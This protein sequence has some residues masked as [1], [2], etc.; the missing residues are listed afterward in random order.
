[1][2]RPKKIGEKNI[3]VSCGCTPAEK[4]LLDEKGISPTQ[5]FREAI[6]SLANK[7]KVVLDPVEKDLAILRRYYV[8]STRPNGD[9]EIYLQ[10]VNLFLQ[11]YS[12]WTKAEVMARAERPRHIKLENDT[13]A[14]E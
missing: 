4:Q 8:Q 9:R 6:R 3:I 2:G 1:M 10:G 5:L 13:G 14:L 7:N 11:K 12:D